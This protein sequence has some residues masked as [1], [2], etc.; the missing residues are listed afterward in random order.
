[1]DVKLTDKSPPSRARSQAL[2]GSSWRSLEVSC[3]RQASESALGPADQ[4]HSFT[5]ITL[6]L[7]D[8]WCAAGRWGMVGHL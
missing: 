1:M 2:A 7:R 5:C 4:Q 8:V 3:S 6:V